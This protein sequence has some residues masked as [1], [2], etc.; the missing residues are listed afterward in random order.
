MSEVLAHRALLTALDRAAVDHSLELTG[1]EA[2]LSEVFAK[3]APSLRAVNETAAE[4]AR[5]RAGALVKEISDDQRQVIRRTVA[6]AIDMGWTDAEVQQ[7]LVGKIGLNKRLNDAVENYR[8]NLLAKG[9]QPGQVNR[10][11]REYTQRLRA[12]RCMT[13]AATEVQKALNDGQRL[14][15][16]QQQEDGEVSRWAVRVWVLHK[17]ERL[18]KV[19][20]P[21][22]GRRATLRKGGGYEMR[23][24]FS[25]GP[26]VHPNCRCSERLV[27]EGIVKADGYRDLWGERIVLGSTA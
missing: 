6:R 17:D 13:I 15:W 9:N 22:N 24:G 5:E 12:Q 4:L 26:P 2:V 11:V 20:R 19:C 18:C 23:V 27:D 21:M 8:Q 10:M 16:Q 1:L 25:P 7:R 14:L 3:A